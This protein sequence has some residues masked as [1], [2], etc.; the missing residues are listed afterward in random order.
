MIFKK[1]ISKLFFSVVFTLLLSLPMAVQLAHTLEDHEHKAC[2]EIA[3]HIH[4]EKLDCS[5]CDFHFASFNFEIQEYSNFIVTS[6][7]SEVI[8]HYFFFESTS[9]YS[10]YPLRAPPSLS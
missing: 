9:K 2:N 4:Q 7:Y 8:N 3:T 5:I 10:S 6:I 1:E